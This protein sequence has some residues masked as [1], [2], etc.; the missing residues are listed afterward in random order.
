MVDAPNDKISVI[1]SPFLKQKSELPVL[2][3]ETHR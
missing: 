3:L 1:S 2:Y